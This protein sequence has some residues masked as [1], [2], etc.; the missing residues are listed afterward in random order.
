MPSPRPRSWP[1]D[2]PEEANTHA[3]YGGCVIADSDHREAA[4]AFMAWL[5]GRDGQAILAEFGFVEP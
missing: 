3:V 5:A 1:I 2:I 4:E